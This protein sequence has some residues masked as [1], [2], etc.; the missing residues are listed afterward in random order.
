MDLNS[1]EERFVPTQ[2]GKC[3]IAQ[4]GMVAT[5]FPTATEA[6]VQMLSQG[7]NAVDAACAA[8][9]ALGV[10]EPQAS[11]IGGQTMALVYLQGRAF[12]IDGSSR[13]P[14]LAHLSA[15]E[16]K[17]DEIGYRATTVPSTPA[18]LG[19]MQRHY[20]RLPWKTVLE[21]AIRIARDGYRITLLQQRLQQ[22]EQN[23]F[24]QVPSLSGAHYFLKTGKTPYAAGDLFT[25]PDLSDC[26]TTLAAEGPESFYAGKIAHWID[27]DMRRHKGF[28][29]KEDLARIPWPTER[30]TIRS[31]YRE[32][33]ILTTPPPTAGRILLMDMKMLRHLDQKYIA[34]GSPTF[35]LILAEILRRGL[36]E[37]QDHPVSPHQYHPEY[38]PILTDDA[39]I[40]EAYLE[41]KKN[42]NHHGESEIEGA[43]E[44]THLS[45]MDAEGNGVGITQ[46]VNLV[47]AS[48]A[49][50]AG[51][52]FLYNNYL[53][54]TERYREDHPHYL[55]PGGSPRSTVTPVIVLHRGQ[56]WLIAGSPGSERIISAVLQFL[57]GIL[58]AGHSMDDAMKAP[59]MH[60]S[61]EGMISL[62]AE[63]FPAD[64]VRF[65]E[66]RGY[67]VHCCEPYAFY[68]GAIHAVLKRQ[69]GLG[70]QGV[71]EIR[72]DGT[73]AGPN[74]SS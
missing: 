37:R 1:I 66:K 42:L 35:M 10:C 23:S 46:S 5:A 61:I 29:R 22:R 58:D 30:E 63:R 65:F 67:A 62:E 26:L 13:I 72:R 60:C 69:T 53:M 21:P 55:R 47:Y 41:V 8:A 50:A 11:G 48:K 25:Q 6:G 4:G 12:A 19:W 57:I 18:V 68:L 31:A 17:D 32:V 14:A 64:L 39:F 54:D 15:F 56:P 36:R 70:F 74:T 52:G 7:G 59:R 27:E 3:A 38:D 16:P 28:L 24:L 73:A 34:A 45:V 51:M 44:T 9:F 33:D 20:G 40:A 71:A 49:A 43:G 2:D